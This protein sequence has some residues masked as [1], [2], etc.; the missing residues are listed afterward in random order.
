MASISSWRQGQAEES[1]KP[2]PARSRLGERFPVNKASSS[3]ACPVA[4]A[5]RAGAASK[6]K[7]LCPPPPLRIPVQPIAGSCRAARQ[8]LAGMTDVL[9]SSRSGLGCPRRQLSWP[10]LPETRGPAGCT[11]SGGLRSR[12]SRPTPGWSGARVPRSQACSPSEPACDLFSTTRKNEGTL[13]R[14]N[15][16]S[17]Y[18]LTG[19]LLC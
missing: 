18:P 17:Q 19:Q 11:G 13:Q 8:D 14:T 6:A 9:A 16:P 5:A 2:S 4:E 1:P 7:G 15:V 12:P 3:L 10:R